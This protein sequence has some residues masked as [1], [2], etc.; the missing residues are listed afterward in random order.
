MFGTARP[1]IGVVHLP[2]LPGSPRWCGDFRKVIS[3]AQA[4]AESLA[5][6]GAHG[7]IVENFGDAPMRRG[8]VGPETVAAM[9]LAVEAVCK[10]TAL[11]LG[12]NVLRNDARSAMAIAAVTGAAFIRVNVHTGA[13]VTD[14]GIIEGRADETL[15]YR[16]SL[17]CDVKIFADVLVK[18]AVPLGDQDLFHAARTTRERGL[19]DALI[20]SGPMTGEPTSLE[21]AATVKRAAPDAPLLIG[22]GVDESN[23]S[24]LLEHADGVIVGTSVKRDG[25][26]SNPV[27]S[28][29]VR[30]LVEIARR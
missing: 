29:R 28:Q 5:E 16:R 22:S 23:I 9:T 19:A 13:M 26:V 18:H 8:S 27:D 3:S 15:R 24:V 14:E 25:K 4:D 20:V 1:V 10:V 11:P 6:G 12:I 21:D 17:G 2:P 30:R 7:M